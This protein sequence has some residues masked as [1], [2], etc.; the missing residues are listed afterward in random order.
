MSKRAAPS[1]GPHSTRPRRAAFTAAA[2]L[3]DP[4][5]QPVVAELSLPGSERTICLTSVDVLEDHSVRDAVF[6]GQRA[7][8]VTLHTDERPKGLP[9]G[10]VHVGRYFDDPG[11]SCPLTDSA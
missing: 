11:D 2:R 3:V 1:A 5:A 6:G 8:V 7:V 9:R 10:T 4:D